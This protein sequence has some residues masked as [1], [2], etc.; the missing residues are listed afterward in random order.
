MKEDDS[1]KLSTSRLVEKE[2][3]HN[4]KCPL[5]VFLRK[6]VDPTAL[7]HGLDVFDFGLDGSDLGG[8]EPGIDF[9]LLAE[10]VEGFEGIVVSTFLD[11]P[12]R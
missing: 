2:E 8:G 3:A 9:M 10:L 5:D 4:D 12:S 6:Q 1:R 11:E 7:L